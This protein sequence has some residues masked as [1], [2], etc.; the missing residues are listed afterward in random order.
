MEITV[1]VEY[2]K[3]GAEGE[4]IAS[5]M[6]VVEVGTDDDGDPITSLVVLPSD[7][8]TSIAVP[9]R[10]RLTKPAQIALD[11]LHEA[12]LSCGKPAP[13]SEHIPAGVN[14]VT[15]AEWRDY[16]YRRGIT[17]SSEARARQQAFKRATEALIAQKV[18]GFWF[19]Y[20]WIA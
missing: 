1:T 5:R 15:E 18:V 8:P 17:T 13:P 7:E 3:D 10:P 4:I 2:L 11:A 9:K 12:V 16:A 6:E 19:P 14:V 20:A